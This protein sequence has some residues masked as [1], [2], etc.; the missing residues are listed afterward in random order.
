M[1]INNKGLASCVT[2]HLLCWLNQPFKQAKGIHGKFKF[3]CFCSFLV[4]VDNCYVPFPSEYLLYFSKFF[5][6]SRDSWNFELKTIE[7]VGMV[8]YNSAADFIALEIVNSR[9]R[10]L[11]GKGSNAVELVSERNVTDG[12]WHNISIAYSPFLV[13]VCLCCNQLLSH[14]LFNFDRSNKLCNF[15][16]S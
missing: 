5:F 1:P 15:S 10:F 3:I 9:L 11:V 13:E 4:R 14:E 12:K 8:L 16:Y 7:T 2:T 6:V